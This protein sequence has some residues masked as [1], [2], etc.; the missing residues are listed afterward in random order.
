MKVSTQIP[1]Y[2]PEYALLKI[3]ENIIHQNY[4]QRWILSDGYNKGQQYF[5]IDKS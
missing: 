3:I 2:Y 1:I 5:Y 4:S